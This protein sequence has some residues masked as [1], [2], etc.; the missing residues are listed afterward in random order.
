[1]AVKVAVVNSEAL[2]RASAIATAAS[3]ARTWVLA[4]TSLA[5]FMVALDA[6]VVSTAL[7]TVA[8]QLDLPPTRTRVAAFKKSAAGASNEAE[9]K[10]RDA[11]SMSATVAGLTVG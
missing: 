10:S 8:R 4:L 2:S 3:P 6:L 9:L 5:S 1:M 11:A 7:T